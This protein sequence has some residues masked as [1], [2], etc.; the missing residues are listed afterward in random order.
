[1]A[2]QNTSSFN[3]FNPIRNPQYAIAPEVVNFLQSD[4]FRVLTSAMPYDNA[5][6]VNRLLLDSSQAYKLAYALIDDVKDKGEANYDANKLV[7]CI[8]Q[9]LGLPNGIEIKTNEQRAQCASKQLQPI[10]SNLTGSLRED[11]KSDLNQ[12][13]LDDLVPL[14]CAFLHDEAQQ[15]R[16]MSAAKQA[17]LVAILYQHQDLLMQ[18]QQ[19]NSDFEHQRPLLLMIANEIGGHAVQFKDDDFYDFKKTADNNIKQVKQSLKEQALASYLC[20]DDFF[21]HL[22]LLFNDQ[23]VAIIQNI[24]LSP[25]SG[26]ETANWLAAEIVKTKLSLTDPKLLANFIVDK[27]TEKE[28]LQLAPVKP[29]QLR[30]E[31][32]ANYCQKQLG[33]DS[34][35]LKQLNV[36]AI[37]SALRES[38]MPLFSQLQFRELV[39]NTIGFLS[40]QEIALL[41]SASAEVEPITDGSEPTAGQ[42]QIAQ[43]ANKLFAFITAIKQQDLLA[44]AE[45]IQFSQTDD[46][47]VEFE[48][49]PLEQVFRSMVTV[50]LNIKDIHCYFNQHNDKGLAD[51]TISSTFLETVSEQMRQIRVAMSYDSHADQLCRRIFFIQGV[52]NGLPKASKMAEFAN[53]PTIE[54]LQR[55][56]QHILRPLWWGNNVSQL[57][58]ALVKFSQA[59]YHNIILTSYYAFTN[60]LKSG[61]NAL[62]VLLGLAETASFQLEQLDAEDLACQEM[63]FSYAQAL[64]HLQPLTAEAIAREPAKQDVIETLEAFVENQEV[65]S[66]MLSPLDET[67]LVNAQVN[68]LI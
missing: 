67:E 5:R 49:S 58:L 63:A 47:K 19:G 14:I 64:N 11:I 39:E 4:D 61:L 6:E 46:A 43:Q 18:L 21:T 44:L 68:Q 62:G 9:A 29:L 15:Q 55:I 1:M 42:Q 10:R 36:T 56:N 23:D 17:D 3:L 13:I 24:L 26:Q 40:E 31:Q 30:V 59:I 66:V 41:L 33:S 35:I 45:L 7:A 25:R 65:T 22:A 20:S 34:E 53:K 27:L 50:M 51:S 8:N 54:R 12:Q 57:S 48:N 38:I 28:G 2:W 16:L 52:R 37:N 60:G 32:A